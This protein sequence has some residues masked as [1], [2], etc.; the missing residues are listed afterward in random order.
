MGS[1]EN[2]YRVQRLQK[3]TDAPAGSIKIINTA[4]TSETSVIDNNI[5]QSNNKVKPLPTDTN[6]YSMPNQEN[7]VKVLPKTQKT[8]NPNEISQ[9]K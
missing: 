4:P 1:G 8:M 9:L 2:H 5:P 3:N 6:N 7:N